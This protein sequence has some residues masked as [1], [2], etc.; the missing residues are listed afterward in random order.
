MGLDFVKDIQISQSKN[1]KYRNL[2]TDNTHVDYGNPFY[3]DYL[4]HK[5]E[6]RRIRFWNRWKNNKNINN[7][8]SPVFYSTRLLW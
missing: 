2:L 4:K 5:S 1:K 7:I 3:Q 6:K 8:H